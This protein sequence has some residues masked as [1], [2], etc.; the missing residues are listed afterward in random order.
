MKRLVLLPWVLVLSATTVS[1]DVIAD[2]NLRTLQSA[3]VLGARRGPSAV[4]DFAAVHL[5]MHDAVQ[6]FERRYEPYC[7]AIGNASGSPVAAASKAA[8]D[9]LV[10]YFPAQQVA[11]DASHASFTAR[12]IADGLMVA[13]DPGED[14]GE[15]AAACILGRRLPKDTTNRNTPDS[16]MG[17]VAVGAWRPTVLNAAGQ[18]VPMAAD[19]L[20]R[21]TPFGLKAID[22]FRTANPPPHLTSGAYAKAYN[23]VKEKG[24]NDATGHTRTPD[25]TAVAR[26]FSDAPANYWNRLM[27]DFVDDRSL[28]LGDSARMFALVSMATADA[29]ISAWDTKIAYNIWRP[30]TAIRDGDNDGNPATVGNPTWTSFAPAPNYPDYTS[31]ANNVSGA[32][33]TVLQHL[34]GDQ[35]DFTLFAAQP[36]PPQPPIP[37]RG[38]SSFSDVARDVVDGRIFMGIHFRF[39]DT[40][41]LR[42]GTHVANWTVSHYLRPIRGG[43]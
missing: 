19:F 9:V 25:E 11:I 34:F 18:P 26:F 8:R 12:Y 6:A 13:D 36:P 3:T 35:V 29:I 17:L 15:R 23:E 33:T 20:A 37:P 7:R 38:Y 21:T 40:A 10:A 32:T 39:A 5:A 31:G 14:V 30:I 2:W 24:A 1:A 22:Q 28:N 27:R 16:F 4:L 43:K 42:Q 41:A